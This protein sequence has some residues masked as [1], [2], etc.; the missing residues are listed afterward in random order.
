MFFSAVAQFGSCFSF[1]WPVLSQDSFVVC[2]DSMF[3][4]R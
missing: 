1:R 3:Y 4:V 2:I